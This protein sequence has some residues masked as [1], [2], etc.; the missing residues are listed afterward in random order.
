MRWIS[1]S[2]A[3]LTLAA[4]AVIR[5]SPASLP[6]TV[7]LRPLTAWHPEAA[8]R[9]AVTR[10]P[11]HVRT[12]R[13]T[14][15]RIAAIWNSLRRL[16]AVTRPSIS[17]LRKA[18][19]RRTVTTSMTRVTGSSVASLTA[20]ISWAAVRPGITAWP[21]A[22]AGITG[23]RTVA[24]R[25]E[26]VTLL[27]AATSV[28]ACRFDISLTAVVAPRPAERWRRAVAVR[29]VAG[30]PGETRASS[31][32]LPRAESAAR[33]G[34]ASLTGAPRAGKCAI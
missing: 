27:V 5:L 20:T 4:R 24:G 23:I 34:A 2:G 10:P 21:Y 12:R 19:I 1:G 3:E 25:R 16:R 22:T 11:T 8:G 28:V 33:P 32:A 9:T 30:L 18:T 13:I 15:G 26:A 14:C 31:A 6:V 29:T 17:F 7:G